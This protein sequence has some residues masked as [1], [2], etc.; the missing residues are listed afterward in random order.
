MHLSPDSDLTGKPNSSKSPFLAAAWLFL[1]GVAL[2]LLLFKL[3][4][5]AEHDSLRQ[6][7]HIE[8]VREAADLQD[9][10]D[11][12]IRAV[13]SLRRLYESSDEVTSQEVRA[14]VEPVL[15]GHPYLQALEW[16]PR[17]TQAD[18]GAFEAAARADELAGFRI[19]ERADDGSMVMVNAAPRAVY[20]PVRYIVPLSGN[21]P[22]LGYDVASQ[23]GRMAVFE[24]ALDSGKAQVSDVFRPVQG[25]NGQFAFVVVSPV[26]RNGLPQDS[27][28]ARRAAHRGYVI[29]LIRASDF[30]QKALH[31]AKPQGFDIELR[32]ETVA[33]T[34]VL[35]YA[36][37]SSADADSV[38]RDLR[39]MEVLDVPGRRWVLRVTATP[40]F[41]R[42]NGDHRADFVLAGGLAL[43]LILSANLFGILRRKARI[44]QLAGDLSR[45]NLELQAV[46]ERLTNLIAAAPMAII[47]LDPEE[48]VT[49]W[50]PAA[51][52][53]FGWRRDEVLGLP[54]PI[55]VREDAHT[56]PT[57]NQRQ[58]IT[59][60]DTARRHKDGVVLPVR[61]AGAPLRDSSGQ[62]SG[63]LGIFEDLSDI[64]RAQKKAR[65]RDAMLEAVNRGA[66]L[67]LQAKHWSSA[68]P[69]LLRA[70]GEAAEVDRA[71]LVAN[72]LA[73]DGMLLSSLQEAWCREG[74]PPLKGRP[75]GQDVPYGPTGLGRWVETLGRGDVLQG[76]VEDFPEVERGL[77]AALGIVSTLLMPIRV[78]DDWWGFIGF[79]TCHARR[80]WGLEEMRLLRITA[81]GLSAAIRR[82]RF[83]ERLRQSALVFA[84]TVDSV[85]IADTESRIL[86][87]NPA[88]TEITGYSREEAIGRKPSL[89]R[90]ERHDHNFYRAMWAVLLREGLW[91]GEI[92]NRRKSGELFPGQLTIRGVVG[93][94]GKPTHYVGVLTDLTAIRETQD[95]LEYLA[96]HDTLTDLPNQR[97]FAMQLEQAI[98]RAASADARL[99]L[100]LINIDRFKDIND[101]LGH[102]AGDV[103]LQ[104]FVG[105]LV[106]SQGEEV[107]VARHGGDGFLALVEYLNDA[108]P[109]AV[110]AQNLLDTL[111]QPFRIMG[112]DVFIG[113]SIGISLYPADDEGA[114]AL[115]RNAEVAMYRA[116]ELGRGR[117]QFYTNDLTERARERLSLAAQ[118]R[119]AM[120]ER[121][122]LLYFQPQLD[123]KTDRVVGA[124][125]LLRWKH[126]EYGM[127]SPAK[128]IPLAEELGLIIPIGDWVLRTACRTARAWCAGDSGFRRIAVNVAGPQLTPQFVETVGRVLA[129]TGLPPACL[130]LE[131][132][133]SFIMGHA[134]GAIGLLHDLKALG[135]EI[136]IDDFGTGYSSLSYLKH[137]P[138]DKL[139]IDQSFVRGIP[140]PDDEAIARAVIGLAKSLRLQVIAEGVETTV[141]RDFLKAEDCDEGQG[142]LYSKPIPGEE[143]EKLLKCNFEESG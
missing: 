140:N 101:S 71:F 10:L 48:R 47:A 54:P 59:H 75:E 43:S 121:Q 95:R 80:E 30:A 109:A 107:P 23:P 100:L 119:R 26:Y 143:F 60:V 37:R 122:L 89:I 85:I 87:V 19:T 57:V 139:K 25:A 102:P 29:G 53:M 132:T 94:A 56:C 18:R 28:T 41:A 20:F 51:E 134:E 124:E 67:L 32:D 137:L 38:E 70:L 27:P 73:P 115:L 1:L 33:D 93:P 2:T 126:P 44:T 11:Y 17:V 133:E 61:I 108:Q 127:V 141:Q 90:S 69:E 130:E 131:V 49:E 65:R 52:R 12:S 114:E 84:Q 113:V 88:F 22:A 77:L 91:R 74:I 98:K 142:Y 79:D 16:A 13:D 46:S 31:D 116:K 76:D 39:H 63:L 36:Q 9:A 15:S 58:A 82:E 3:A 40:E 86:D 8:T 68:M 78:D 64:D 45:T 14:F 42:I 35:M 104:Q 6:K 81:K 106:A 112:H 55:M 50:N 96:H 128:F 83:E 129:E 34:P 66:R 117:Y 135:V 120:A 105:R 125:A 97:L 118:L 24:A 5:D 4:S 103:L 138:I 21:E 72:H 123:L 110:A 7:L 62:L 111:A 92:W 136:A 99:A